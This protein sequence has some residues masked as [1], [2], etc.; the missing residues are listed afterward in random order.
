MSVEVGLGNAMGSIGV[1]LHVQLGNTMATEVVRPDQA[2]EIADQI[3]RAARTAEELNE[4][5][6]AA[7]ARVTKTWGA[8]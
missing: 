1:M 3:I 8:P 6:E 7:A 2:V 5:N 4:A